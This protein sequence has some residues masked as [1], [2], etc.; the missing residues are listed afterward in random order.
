MSLLDALAAVPPG[1]PFPFTPIVAALGAFV[2]VYVAA[3]VLAPTPS[4]LE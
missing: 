4:D 1:W 3:Y 2:V